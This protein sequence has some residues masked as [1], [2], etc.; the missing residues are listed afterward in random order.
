MCIVVDVVVRFPSL[1]VRVN[2]VCRS[3]DKAGH[4]NRNEQANVLDGL[5]NDRSKNHR[6]NTARST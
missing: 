1:V 5:K 3:Q 2:D 6:G 4:A